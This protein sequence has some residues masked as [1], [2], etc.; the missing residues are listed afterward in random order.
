MPDFEKE[1]I[2]LENGGIFLILD[3]NV[4]AVVGESAHLMGCLKL[5][6]KCILMVAKENKDKILSRKLHYLYYP[7]KHIYETQE[8]LVNIASYAAVQ[9]AVLSAIIEVNKRT[10]KNNNGKTQ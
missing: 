10:E 6:D 1:K 5:L 8:E 4:G 3:G 9:M 2:I 7:V